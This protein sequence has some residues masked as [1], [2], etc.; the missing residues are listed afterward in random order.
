MKRGADESGL[1]FVVRI[2]ELILVKET[3]LVIGIGFCRQHM[4]GTDT[5]VSDVRDTWARG[6]LPT[7]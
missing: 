6:K 2:K 5:D 3:G 4:K 1:S 7:L